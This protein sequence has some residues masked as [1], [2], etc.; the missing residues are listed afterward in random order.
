MKRKSKLII[1]LILGLI[2]NVSLGG[3]IKV[4]AYEGMESNYPQGLED[5]EIRILENGNY[6]DLPL[7]G[8]ETKDRKALIPLRFI[9]EESGYKV[10]WVPGKVSISKGDKEYLLEKSKMSYQ[11][12]I[13][14]DR[15]LVDS[16]YFNRFPDLKTSYD[17]ATKT[18]ILSN[19]S[20]KKD[21]IYYDFGTRSLRTYLDQDL[22]YRLNG[23][24]AIPET[25]KNPLVLILHGSHTITK[26]E[27]NR[28]DLGFSYLMKDLAEQGYAVLSMNVNMQYSFEDGEPI[29]S[30]RVIDIF[31]ETVLELKAINEGKSKLKEYKDLEGKFDLDK[32]ILI[33]HSRAGHEI[34]NLTN[35]FDGN[36]INIEGLISI[37]PSRMYEMDYS[38]IDQ[39]VSIILPELDGDVIGLDGQWIFDELVDNPSRNTTSQEIFLYGANHNAFNQAIL[40]QDEGKDWYKG[41]KVK[42]SPEKQRKFFTEHVKVFLRNIDENKDLFLNQTYLEKKFKDYK[43]IVSNFKN[44]YSIF[45]ANNPSKYKTNAQAKQ[46]IS[47]YNSSINTAASFNP[48]GDREY[49]ELLNVQWKK[50]GKYIEFPIGE[51]KLEGKEFL[52]LYFALDSTDPINKRENQALT[53]ILEDKSGNKEEIILSSERKSLQYQDGELI[54]EGRTYSSHTPLAISQI[55]LKDLKNLDLEN[56][57]S[58][59]LVFD[60]NSQGSIMI[61]RI[62]LN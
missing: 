57:S 5:Y 45:D 46:L 17:I 56:L 52:S 62:D 4:N 49:L 1:I 15:I 29:E 28:Y 35:K 58:L 59:K 61:K 10:D 21:I 6:I 2:I 3:Q 32:V 23:G 30:E 47:S 39:P 44:G 18:V 20:K 38:G 11:Y 12:E 41:E 31:K 40:K 33:G 42:I 37:A 51:Y 34:F 26:S 13:V 54:L 36:L 48:P 50:K 7:E 16:S 27:E 24:L 8:I 60:Q 55:P 9:L 43:L 25:D 19:D 14:E 53:L 22:E